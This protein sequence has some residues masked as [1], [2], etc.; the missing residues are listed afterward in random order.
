[1]G[2]YI[3]RRLLL[4]IPTFLGVTM[5]VFL[6]TRAVPGGP[7]EQAVLRLRMGAAMEGGQ[8]S[9]A[10][11]QI[12][13]SAM[14][15]LKKA[16]DLDK[17]WYTAYGL[18]LKKIVTFDLGNSYAQ[19][20]PVAKLIY[21]R[22]PISVYFGLVS[23]VL[24]YLVCVPLGIL[25]ALRH[26]TPFDLVSSAVVFLGYSIPGWALGALLLVLLSSGRFLD[27]FPL[28]GFR[29]ASFDELP[30]IVK[31]I[32]DPDRLRD[33][34]GDFQWKRMSFAGKAVDQLWHT[35][36]PIVCYMVGSFATLTILTKNTLLDVLGQDYIRTAY[37]K[38]LHPRRIFFLH[39]LRNSLIPL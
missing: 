3:V 32:E 11:G 5:V 15:E 16:F 18:W 35:F 26:G 28:G 30:S 13:A 9:D 21:N 19:R 36:L 37:A 22:L 6:I 23:F 7:L 24:T 10:S 14:E 2:A 33:E 8:G 4:M 1:M 38:G 39:A 17:P 34:F 27:V 25:K 29:S 31:K 12:P 20:E